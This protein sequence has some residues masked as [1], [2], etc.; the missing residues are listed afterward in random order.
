MPTDLMIDRQ[1]DVTTLTLSRP[2]SLNALSVD[3]VEALIAALAAAAGDGTRLLVVRGAGKG[4]CGGFDLS[5]VEDE[6]DGDLVLRLIRVETMLQALYHLPCVTLGLAHGRSFGAG[7]DIVG[8]C[9]RRVGAPGT[10][11][12]MPGFRFGVALG[13]ARLARVVGTDNARYLLGATRRFTAEEGLDLGF[14]T[15]I[16]GQ[17]A[18]DQ[19]IED[20]MRDYCDLMP[21]ATAVMLERTRVDSRD[22]DMATLVRSAAEPGLKQRI[23][24]YIA[25][26][27]AAREVSR[28]AG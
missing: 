18:W 28:A 24:A 25:A 5:N 7:T 10:V 26:V 13:T 23:T 27:R 20:T 11:F 1:D 16:A 12:Q 2:E 8:A 22:A 15:G 14:L 21:G 17:N 19:V 9:V 4:F 6:G 3:M